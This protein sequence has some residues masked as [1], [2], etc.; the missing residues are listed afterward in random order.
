M[1]ENLVD[2]LF[3]MEM[4]EFEFD[5]NWYLSFSIIKIWFDLHNNFRQAVVIFFHW[6]K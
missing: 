4:G 1:A 5:R 2:I 6:C 3:K